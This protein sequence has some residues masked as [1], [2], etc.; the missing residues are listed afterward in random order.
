[1]EKTV[2]AA[3]PQIKRSHFSKEWMAQKKKAIVRDRYLYLL[4][5][6]P[7]AYFIIFKYGPMIGLQIAFKDYRINE[8]IFGSAWVGMKHFIRLFSTEDFYTILSNTIILSVSNI[9]FGF[10]MPIILAILL[11][12]VRNMPF[13]R[14][15][16]SLLY[17]PHFISWIVLGGIITSILSP[18]T[19]VVN[20]I[21]KALGFESIYF[22]GD[23][24]WWRIIYVISGIWKEAG[25]GTIIYLA[26]ITGINGEL[27][28]AA[29]IDGANK[30]RQMWHITLPG[31]RS[32]IAIMLIMRMGS[33]LQ[34][35]F[36]QIYSLQ[37]DMVLSVSDVISTYEYRIGLLNMQYSYTTALGLFKG[38]VGLILVAGTNYVVKW[39]SDGE[40]SLW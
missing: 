24:G 2:N 1:M 16:Q 37:N 31:I 17:M 7:L 18:S 29:R 32:T 8:G 39:I 12:E 14:V 5:L 10:P 20:N 34:I 21:I 40:S 15:T 6:F 26:A 3:S 27:Y 19:G 25:W 30:L 11:N 13:K 22:M 9:V 38:L 36:E 35:G 4:L 23:T 28:E 33:V